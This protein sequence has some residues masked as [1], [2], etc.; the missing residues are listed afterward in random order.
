M[1]SVLYTCGVHICDTCLK[2]YHM[3]LHT[4][5]WQSQIEN[6]SLSRISITLLHLKCSIS[7]LLLR[8]GL[9]HILA[10]MQSGFYAVHMSPTLNGSS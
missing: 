3:A 4:C 8:V 2:E 7:E 1:Y 10:S 5:I 9:V 6:D